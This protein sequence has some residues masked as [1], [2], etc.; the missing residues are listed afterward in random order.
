MT[1]DVLQSGALVVAF[2]LLWRIAR[3]QSALCDAWEQLLEVLVQ[4]ANGATGDDAVGACATV[5]G[6]IMD[7]I[8]ANIRRENARRTAAMTETTKTTPQVVPRPC[9]GG[10]PAVMPAPKKK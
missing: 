6:S 1:V 4:G 8:A 2:Y 3:M 5:N 7:A 10:P 9:K